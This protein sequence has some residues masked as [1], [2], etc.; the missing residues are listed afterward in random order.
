MYTFPLMYKVS[1]EQLVLFQRTFYKR[2]KGKT[3][4]PY[5]DLA[6]LGFDM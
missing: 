1:G 6:G 3:R 4:F 5:V 2:N